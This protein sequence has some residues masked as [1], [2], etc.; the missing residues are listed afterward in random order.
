MILSENKVYQES[1]Q[2]YSDYS[3]R[4]QELLFQQG[5]LTQ[6]KNINDSIEKS[7]KELNS[8]FWEAS[9]TLNEE[10]TKSKI[11]IYREFVYNMVTKIYSPDII[12]YFDIG[13][14]DKHKTRRPLEVKL[15]ITGEAGEGITE[16]KKNII[17]YLVYKFN[18]E[19]EILIQDSSCYNGIDPRQVSNMLLE[20][21]EISNQVNKQAIVA[22]NKYQLD[23]DDSHP[24]SE[25]F[26]K[27]MTDGYGIILS[28]NN[29][30]L[31]KWIFKIFLDQ[32]FK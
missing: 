5:Q 24:V 16:V 19:L 2:L 20:L 25:I 31:K 14:K 28:E 11:K 23:I 9:Q 6:A 7:E 27:S 15:N 17:D 26:N 22:I 29:K 8:L 12:T 18:N 1:M 30:L 13:I 3:V 4:L 21:N 32:K 10:T